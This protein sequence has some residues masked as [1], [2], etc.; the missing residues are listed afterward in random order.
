MLSQ[1]MLSQHLAFQHMLSPTLISPTLVIPPPLLYG[2]TTEWHLYRRVM[3][4][5]CTFLR[6]VCGGR[7]GEGYVPLV[8]TS[9]Q[10]D[11]TVSTVRFR[12]LYL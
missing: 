6:E 7:N 5:I 9:T 4:L 3:T 11:T 2:F 12:T 10:P 1:R 8:H